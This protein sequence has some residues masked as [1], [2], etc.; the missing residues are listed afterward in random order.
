VTGVFLGAGCKGNRN[1][2]LDV[3][4]PHSLVSTTTWFEIGAFKDSSCGAI[5]PM[6]GGGIP[7]GATSRLAFRRD[8]KTTPQFGD[9]PNGKYAFGAVARDDTCAVIALGCHE[10]DV[11]S[12]DTVSIAMAAVEQPTGK[13][14]VGASC[15][16]AKCVPANDN[17]DPSVGAGC[18]LEVVGA[19]PLAEPV[20][21]LGSSSSQCAQGTLV[22]A[23]AIAPTSGGF[24]IAYREIDPNGSGAKLTLLPIDLGGGAQPPVR[25]NLAN[26]CAN[27]GET[28]GIGLVINGADGMIA[29]AK[30]PC[31]DKPLLELLNF[32]V[33]DPK[34]PVIGQHFESA[35]PEPVTL[36]PARSAAT[37]PSGS[38]VVFTQTGTGLIASMDPAQG[39]IAPNGT[40][41]AATGITNT[42]VAGTD[43]VLALLAA[44]KGSG[45][46]D[47]DSGL[48]DPSGDGSSLHLLMVPADTPINTINATTQTP[49]PAI[50]FPGTWGS[51]A[52]RDGR[53]IV[54]SD[55]SGP[56]RSATYRAF[57][58]NSDKVADENGFSVTGSS[59]VTAGDVAIVGNRAY[60]AV[61]KKGEVALH[62]YDNATTTLTPIHDVSFSKEPRISASTLVRDGRVAVAATDSRVVVAWTTATQLVAYDGSG[63]YAVFGC[64][65]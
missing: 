9:I 47:P 30:A 1:V 20:S 36:G 2:N 27:S 59:K 34:Q 6:L 12:T 63:G 38:L 14:G 37:V 33:A 58:L 50:S 61:L 46:S 57:D 19:G 56:G 23:P 65:K 16:A 3:G 28:D 7:G 32:N 29:L 17:S 41:G 42:W 40:F 49:R 54:L 52:A 5:A 4:V 10:D 15:Q 45:T 18:S 51:V 26:R 25:P 8:A 22:S 43:K 55:G 11:G 39:V 35:A 53:V 64:T 21:C 31:S 13:C 48:A 62:V 60:F 24:L 44:G